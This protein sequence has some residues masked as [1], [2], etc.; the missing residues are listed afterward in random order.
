MAIAK[1]LSIDPMLCHIHMQ[2][3]SFQG[4]E[5]VCEAGEFVGTVQ[6]EGYTITEPTYQNQRLHQRGWARGPSK[7]SKS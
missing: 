7:A 3:L 5:V 1:P 4:K 6:R 2:P